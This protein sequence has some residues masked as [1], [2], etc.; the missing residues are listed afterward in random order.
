MT[1]F[2]GLDIGTTHIGAGVF[3][4]GTGGSLLF[5]LQAVNSAAVYHGQLAELDLETL[6]SLV[7]DILT[8]AAENLG[9]RKADLAGM[10]ITGQQ[11]GLALLGKAN[12][13]LAPAITWQDRRTLIPDA[14]GRTTLA[15]FSA[16]AGGAEAFLP[17]GCSPAAGY[18]GPS[19]YWLLQHNLLPSGCTACLIPDAVCAWLTGTQPV[20]DPTDAGS[21][22]LYDLTRGDWSQ[23]V[24]T[25][26]GIPGDILAQV[27]LTGSLAGSLRSDL[28]SACGLP[29]NLPVA[30]ALGDNQASFLGSVRSPD[31]SLL[32]NVGTGAQCSALVSGFARLDGLDTRSFPGGRFLF[33]GAGLFGGRS[34][35][36]L[37]S[38][39]QQVGQQ[40][41]GVTQETELYDRMN[42]LAAAV[43]PG[44]DGL[45]CVP[46]FSGTRLDP[47]LRASYNGISADNLTPGH[48]ARAL[49]EG[50]GEIFFDFSEH[51]QPVTGQ[52]NILVGAGNG[53]RR[54]ALFSQILAARWGLPLRLPT[55]EEEATVGAAL[56]A[57]VAAGC[58]P[59]WAAASALVV[60]KPADLA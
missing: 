27:R 20:T 60:D 46:L 7:Q 30:V 44:C 42:R 10:G 8:S 24:L 25:R 54:N 9:P 43:P 49:L 45:R 6:F 15:R 28:A 55:W 33:V 11:H 5:S 39:F 2:L 47:E 53:I 40:L 52:R 21:T 41:F 1:L 59:D 22:A 19:L 17:M 14:E 32:L 38:L 4:V 36:Y 31:E 56:C 12:R 35:A 13:P 51:L 37:Q 18:L 26:T 3:E 50:M 58:V 57:A 48:L 29:P 23:E 34:Y 16:Q